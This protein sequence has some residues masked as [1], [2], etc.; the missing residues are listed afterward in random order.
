MPSS[1]R[2]P[3]LILRA[4]DMIG[5]LLLE[6]LGKC[7][8]DLAQLELGDLLVRELGLLD[9]AHLPLIALVVERHLVGR[10]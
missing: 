7:G 5:E 8:P 3:S 9:L 2:P 6:E 10:L 4:L 1:L